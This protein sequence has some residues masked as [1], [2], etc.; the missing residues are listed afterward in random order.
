MDWQF[1]D[2]QLRAIA[3]NRAAEDSREAAFLCAAQR[4]R[5]WERLGHVSMIDY[6]E[7]VLGYG[8]R[9]ARERLRV[10]RALEHLP[11]ITEALAKGELS[12]SAVRE[13]SRVATSDTEHAW[14]SAAEGKNLRDV[15]QLVAGHGPGDLP[16]DLPDPNLMPRRVWFEVSPETFALFRQARQELEKELGKALDDDELLAVLCRRATE[17]AEPSRPQHQIAITTCEHC[18]RA[19][20]RGGGL[21]VE[22]DEATV[23]LAHCDSE[24]VGS[25]DG[26][27]PGRA[28]QGIPKATRRFVFRRDHGRCQVPGCRSARNLDIHHIEF[29]SH[30]GPPTPANLL[31]VCGAHHRAIH[32]R[33]LSVKGTAPDHLEFEQRVVKTPMPTGV[34][35]EDVEREMTHVGPERGLNAMAREAL[36]PAPPAPSPT[37]SAP[38]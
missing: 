7:R 5:I 21:D 19:W 4:M 34:T 32:R 10:A 14:L 11:Q 15:E 20:Q 33:L 24:H 29:K 35:N 9:A 8:P 17:P 27:R 18:K 2:A 26:E 6:M 36:G 30:N 37:V 38:T 16:T 28:K 22:I 12:Y 31:L 3:K 25:L 13:L 23:E 1:I